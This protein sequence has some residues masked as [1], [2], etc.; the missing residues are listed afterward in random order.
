M[1][2]FKWAVN[3]GDQISHS[4]DDKPCGDHFIEKDL[5]CHDGDAHRPDT[6]NNPYW[7]AGRKGP[8][9]E[10]PSGKGKSERGERDR[11]EITKKATKKKEEREAR[12]GE[13]TPE[14]IKEWSADRLED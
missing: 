10:D 2:K 14:T 12:E 5:E 7:Q 1:G 6:G 3:A 8:P 9:S 13:I 11:R 4:E